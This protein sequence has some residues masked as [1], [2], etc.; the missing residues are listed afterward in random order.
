[1]DSP[2]ALISVQLTLVALAAIAAQINTTAMSF[3]GIDSISYSLIC[4]EIETPISHSFPTNAH[5]LSLRDNFS[6]KSINSRKSP[7]SDT[8]WLFSSAS[9]HSVSSCIQFAI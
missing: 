3:N 2:D 4:D 5:L 8:F 1:M 6:I 9:S 7:Q